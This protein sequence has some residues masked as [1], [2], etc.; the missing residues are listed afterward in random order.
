[1]AT[2]Q[3]SASMYVLAICPLVL[4][5]MLMLFSG[6]ATHKKIWKYLCVYVLLVEAV[7]E[8]KRGYT[9][10]IISMSVLFTRKLPH[11]QC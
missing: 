6:V 5:Q 3:L 2:E 9:Q 7:H 10:H 11:L 1:M 4:S 8:R